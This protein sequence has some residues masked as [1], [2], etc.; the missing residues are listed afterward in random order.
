MNVL[1][2]YSGASAKN[3]LNL[4]CC[5]VIY[6]LNHDTEQ[7]RLTPSAPPTW[8]EGPSSCEAKCHNTCQVGIRDRCQRC[9]K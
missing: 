2:D 8:T 3:E 4:F 5:P 7:D 1:Q 9:Y 6:L